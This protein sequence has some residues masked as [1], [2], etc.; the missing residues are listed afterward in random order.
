MGAAVIMTVGT[1]C[2]CMIGLRDF[3]WTTRL[4]ANK[5]PAFTDV[6]SRSL[7]EGELPGMSDFG[8]IIA[9]MAFVA[10]LRLRR[11]AVS[12]ECAQPT[13]VRLKF[14]FLSGVFAPLFTVQIF[15]WVISRARPNVFLSEVLPERPDLVGDIWLPG[16]MGLM[17]PRGYMWNSVPSGHAS[18]CA[19][20]LVF[21]YA[22]GKTVWQKSL[23][24]TAVI[25]YTAAMA[26]ARSMA[27]MHWI[28]DSVASFF[29]VWAVI[30]IVYQKVALG[31]I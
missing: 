25:A 31:K 12:N 26:I 27:G 14:I 23:I 30:D 4:L 9:I 18:T 2:F 13:L 3:E 6:M 17:G 21:S 16:F 1:V 29:I 10:W 20:L 24:G 19:V 22:Y 7:F 11:S 8:V 5:W 15:K 28:S